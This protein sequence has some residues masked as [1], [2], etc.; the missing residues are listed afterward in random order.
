[1]KLNRMAVKGVILKNGRSLMDLVSR[2]ETQMGNGKLN[3]EDCAMGK[4][5]FLVKSIRCD[6]NLETEETYKGRFGCTVSD[7][8]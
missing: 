4:C 1:M 2:V 3:F 7:V 8:Y 5:A 6:V